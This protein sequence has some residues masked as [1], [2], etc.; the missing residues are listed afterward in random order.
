MVVE[1]VNLR[2][3]LDSVVVMGVVV[4]KP[5]VHVEHLLVA[6]LPHELLLFAEPVWMK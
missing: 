2:R 1:W 6:K 5:V 3:T 4:I